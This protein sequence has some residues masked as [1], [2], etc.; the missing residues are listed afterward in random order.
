MTVNQVI[1][2]IKAVLQNHAMINTVLVSTPM[3]WINKGEVPL[4]PVGTFD[5]SSGFLNIGREQIHRVDMWLLDQSGKDGE[6]E[7]EV[8]SDMHGVAYDVVSILRKGGN[9]WIIS[10]RV[11]WQAISEK[12]EDY[13][14]GVRI[15]FDFIVVRDYGSCDTPTKI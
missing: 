2:E 13:L 4:Y 10:D 1:Q 15:T 3:E 12:F 14:S 5:I 11:Q 8:I 9:P 7:Q 6:F